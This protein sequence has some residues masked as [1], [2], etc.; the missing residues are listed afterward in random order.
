MTEHEHE[1]EHEHE[2]D[3]RA[4]AD[5]PDH[6]HGL[7]GEQES[8]SD[9]RSQAKQAHA[10]GPAGESQGNPVEFWE[11]HYSGAAPV[12]SGK[13]NRTLAD[14]VAGWTPGTSLDLGCGEGGDV[15]WLAQLG[16]NATGIDLSATAIARAKKQAGMEQGVVNAR[17]IVGD[18]AEWVERGE[19]VDGIKESLDLVT[20]SFFQSPVELPRER[21][22]RAAVERLA[23]GGRLVLL[24]HAAPPPW[25]TGLGGGPRH[26]F[27]PE[28]E[29]QALGFDSSG[30]RGSSSVSLTIVTAEVR[31]REV[32]APDGSPALIDDTLVV[33]Q[34]G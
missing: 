10:H 34:R 31:A 11:Q 26:F 14:T 12:W 32:T 19:E 7:A 3:S 4:L 33:V 30:L 18:L 9:L 29:L 22:L 1:H 25:A 28:D 21:I 15:L 17:F 20:A 23:V 2:R 5:Q 8:D 27:T 6:S 13:V 24:S 16:W